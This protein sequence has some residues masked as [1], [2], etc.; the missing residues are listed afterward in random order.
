MHKEKTKEINVQWV[1]LYLITTRLNFT[2]NFSDQNNPKSKYQCK[3]ELIYIRD[4]EAV[5]KTRSRVLSGVKTH[6]FASS[7]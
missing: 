2:S 5:Q 4:F 3:N 7:F 6:G 1:C